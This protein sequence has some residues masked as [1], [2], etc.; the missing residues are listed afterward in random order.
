M[1]FQEATGLSVGVWSNGGTVLWR[2]DPNGAEDAIA[3]GDGGREA[4]W[5]SWVRLEVN[6]L[7]RLVYTL[8]TGVYSYQNRSVVEVDGNVLYSC[9]YPTAEGS[10]T[11]TVTLTNVFAEA[12]THVIT[13]RHEVDAP[14]YFYES[15]GCGLTLSGLR[16]LPYVS[17]TAYVVRFVRS[18]DV[19][20]PFEEKIFE[21]EQVV[22][23]P[24]VASLFA[25]PPGKRFVG[26][27]CS[28]GRRYDDGM[29]VFDLAEPGETVTMTAIWE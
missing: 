18:A 29:L 11:E 28:N 21:R 8:K 5:D 24:V 19:D 1:S 23:L 2:L 13:W 27:A 15:S 10:T 17:P 4:A 7:G 16:W 14:K 26:W 25:P 9:Q 22:N 6:G 12:G 3:S 20:S